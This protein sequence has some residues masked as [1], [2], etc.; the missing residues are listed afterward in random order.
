MLKMTF[1]KI[2]I[3]GCGAIGETLAKFID[4]G[5]AGK[6]EL[7][8]LF[9]LDPERAENLTDKLSRSPTLARSIDEVLEDESVDLVV[10]A[11]S[12]KAVSEYAVDILESG[13]DLI[14][15]SVGAFAD[16]SFFNK[17][18]ELAEKLDQNIYIPS[19]AILGLDG[20]QAAEIAGFDEVVL[21]TRKPPATLAETKFVKERGIDLSSL[22]DSEVIFEGSASEAVEE[23][24]SSVNVAAS[25]SLAGAGFDE[26]S[27]R[28]VAD[29]SLERN[30]HEIQIEGEAGE[31]RTQAQNFPS[32]DNPKTSYLAALSAIRTLKNL[33]A[34]ICIGA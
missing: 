18:E 26:T 13:K 6:T 8:V 12:Q 21:I 11:A 20:V 14:V 7:G 3:I 34:P 4:R 19:G 2:A 16:E 10:E 30:L 17:V 25:L 22:E 28:V 5:E 32:P 27:V 33:T 31:Y 1:R 29:P 15:L 24:P 23:F 9:D